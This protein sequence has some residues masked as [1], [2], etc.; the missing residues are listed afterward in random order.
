MKQTKT[1]IIWLLRNDLRLHDNEVLLRATQAADQVVPLYCFDPRHVG[2]TYYFNFPKTGPPRARFQLEA[3]EDLRHSLR[4]KGSDLVIRHGKPEDVVPELVQALPNVTAVYMQ[5]EVCSE[6]V[7]VEKRLKKKC[8]V[9]VHLFWGS[10]LYHIDHVLK[11]FGSVKRV[12]DVYTQFRKRMEEEGVVRPLFSTPATLKPVPGEISDKGD[13]PTPGELLKDA[14]DE[15]STSCHDRS[16]FPFKGGETEA[17][18]RLNHYFWETDHLQRYFETRNGLVGPDYSSKFSPWLALGCISPCFINAERLRYEKER[19]SNKSTYWLFFEL[20]WRD[21]FKFVGLKYGNSIFHLE[22]ISEKLQQQHGKGRD[23]YGGKQ[24]KHDELLF[25]A[26][27]EGRT[28]IPWVDANMRELKA[29]GFM[30]NRGRQNV[31]SFL[32]KDLKLDWRM[33][34]EWFEYLLLDHDPTSNY[35]NWQYASGVGND[36]REN[37]HFNMLKQAKDYDPNGEFVKRWCPEVAHIPP[38]KVHAPWTLSEEEQ[39]RY[40]CVIGD[41]YPRPTFIDPYWAHH[42]GR[43]A[44]APAHQQPAPHAGE[45]RKGGGAP[46][47]QRGKPRNARVE[48]KTKN[49]GGKQ[50]TLQGWVKSTASDQ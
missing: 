25:K 31:A 24:W 20:L 4:A 22:G 36:P 10:T 11:V 5:N 37:R 39:R 3:L 35:C 15:D 26:W 40:K 33:G 17:L 44:H 6:E 16:A 49:A 27:S 2:T 50:A 46:A 13:L 9:P 48:T 19:V 18:K 32:S 8:T 43:P 45:K 28:G 38:Q 12:P 47:G 30:S 21:Y 41:D 42:H 1:T 29:T 23:N 34:A 7:D 14:M